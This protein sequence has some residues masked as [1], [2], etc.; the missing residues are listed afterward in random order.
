VFLR[1]HKS[2]LGSPRHEAR[3][4]SESPLQHC[5]EVSDVQLVEPAG[6]FFVHSRVPRTRL[7]HSHSSAMES[8]VLVTG[9]PDDVDPEAWVGAGNTRPLYC[10][11]RSIALPGE[12]DP[13]AGSGPFLALASEAKTLHTGI[14]AIAKVARSEHRSALVCVAPLQADLGEP[15]T[16][17]PP[18][19]PGEALFESEAWRE[20]EEK[21]ES[22]GGKWRP[23]L[24]SLSALGDVP[25]AE[26]AS[27][28]ASLTS[29]WDAI[30]PPPSAKGKGSS[31]RGK[32]DAPRKAASSSRTSSKGS[33][34]KGKDRS[35]RKPS[36]KT[37]QGVN[38]ER[39]CS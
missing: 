36:G 19:E 15:L 5:G 32:A 33:S 30:R 39:R 6:E 28:A 13:D 29:G 37:E 2:R 35:N 9:V 7:C 10:Q 31:R 14:P 26:G 11:S 22:V 12:F 38:G 21:L 18:D 25:A 4:H 34:K 1:Q 24:F 27:A 8:R 20:F 17:A 23:G 16:A 3:A